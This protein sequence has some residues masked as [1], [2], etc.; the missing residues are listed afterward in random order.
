MTDAPEWIDLTTKTPDVTPNQV[1]QED[2]TV[3]EPVVQ[4]TLTPF[5]DL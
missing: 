1:N 4:S 5:N 3:V 2:W